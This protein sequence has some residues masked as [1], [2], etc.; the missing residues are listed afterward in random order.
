MDIKPCGETNDI[1]HIG[2]KAAGTNITRAIID[3]WMMCVGELLAPVAQLYAASYSETPTFQASGSL[4]RTAPEAALLLT[5]LPPHASPVSDVFWVI[6][7]QFADLV[8]ELYK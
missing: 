5:G 1:F 6:F 4:Y 2:S 3:G 7:C 8:A